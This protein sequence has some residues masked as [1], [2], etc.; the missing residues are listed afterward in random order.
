MARLLEQAEAILGKQDVPPLPTDNFDLIG[1]R[2]LLLEL[3]KRVD[4]LEETAVTI[5]PRI[6]KII[7][8][9]TVRCGDCGGTGNSPHLMRLTNPP[10]PV[11]CNTCKGK[12]YLP[13]NWKEQSEIVYG[14]GV[15]GPFPEYKV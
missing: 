6:Q 12:G 9:D 3:A 5:R 8:R 2:L 10:R 14:T 7:P 1:V 15:K 13:Y 4:E 11:S